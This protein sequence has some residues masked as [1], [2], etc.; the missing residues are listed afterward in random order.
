VNY[1]RELLKPCSRPSNQTY[2]PTHKQDLWA[3][4]VHSEQTKCQRGRG[5]HCIH[6]RIW[7]ANLA[8]DAFVCC[9]GVL[10]IN[11][12]IW[13]DISNILHSIILCGRSNYSSA[14][15]EQQQKVIQVSCHKWVATQLKAQQSDAE[16]RWISIQ[17]PHIQLRIVCAS[18]PCSINAKLLL[19]CRLHPISGEEHLPILPL[20]ILLAC[21]WP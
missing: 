7:S 11:A 8:G 18:S 15:G 19:N 17:C 21:C 6:S 2:G 3:T 20:V 9:H 4:L 14:G 1:T 10:I 16:S 13:V 12:F 5:D